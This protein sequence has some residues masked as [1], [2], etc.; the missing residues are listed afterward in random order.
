MLRGLLPL[1]ENSNPDSAR[2]P[3]NGEA[4][5]A[6]RITSAVGLYGLGSRATLPN[7]G[8]G[9]PHVIAST[10]GVVGGSSHWHRRRTRRGIRRIATLGG[11]SFRCE[12]EG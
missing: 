4:P 2:S 6:H 8:R 9:L 7:L 1:G 12:I 3:T 10:T 11:T 5:P